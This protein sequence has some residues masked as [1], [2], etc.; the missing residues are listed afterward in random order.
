MNNRELY[1]RSF[2]RL[3]PSEQLEKEILQMMNEK[4]TPVRFHPRKLIALTAALVAV[5]SLAL[6][7]SAS[8]V[9]QT[10]QVWVGDTLLG[11][12]TYTTVGEGDPASGAEDVVYSLTA[13]SEPNGTVVDLTFPVY[14]FCEYRQDRHILC[15]NESG[16]G[17]CMELDVTEELAD[18]AYEDTIT[19][20]GYVCKVTLAGTGED[21]SMIFTVE[22]EA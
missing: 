16:T 21:V 1:R 3:H 13:D 5:L 19:A 12:Y 11:D 2:D 15:I 20:F 18:G 9:L 8:G 22:G 7:A 14:A 6:M 10:V 17:E 4:K